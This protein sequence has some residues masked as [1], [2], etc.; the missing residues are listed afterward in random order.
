MRGFTQKATKVVTLERGSESLEVTLHAIP[1][2]F[3]SWLQ[4]QFPY[5]QKFIK[6]AGQAGTWIKDE[7]AYAEWDDLF[8]LL[9]LAKAMEPEAL[10]EHQID[11]SARRN[12]AA[13][14]REAEAVLE[15]LRGAN[16][17]Q[18]NIMEL[19][20]G[21]FTAGSGDVEERGKSSARSGA[22]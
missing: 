10:L 5:P 19:L 6:G 9:L 12:A 21:A 4:A 13:W 17:T 1:A 22:G 3:R 14:R 18:A 15:E 2:G 7:A 16:L 20:L 8:G 11:W